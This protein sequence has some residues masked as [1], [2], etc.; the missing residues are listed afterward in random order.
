M[1]ALTSLQAIPYNAPDAMF[2]L[3]AEYEADTCKRELH[4]RVLMLSWQHLRRSILDLALIKV[5]KG[6]IGYCHVSARLRSGWRSP[7]PGHEY[8]PLLGLPAFRKGAREVIF[9]KSS[10]LLSGPHVATLQTVSGTGAV[11][12]AAL[13]LREFISPKAK[14]YVSDPS[15]SNHRVIFEFLGFEVDDYPY[16]DEDSG[17]VAF[18]KMLEKMGAADEGSIL[19]LHPCAHNPTGCDLS[20]EQW[21]QVAEVM[22]RRQ[23]FPVLDCAYQG[24]ASGDLDRDG[25]TIRY[26]LE[27]EKLNGLVCQSFSKSMG[28][29]RRASR[30]A[31]RR[32]AF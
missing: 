11:H 31:S 10:V 27:E 23:L 2:A 24:F 7:P 26:M 22:R 3:K 16:Y 8:L 4:E 30:R 17:S 19:I 18:Q 32:C 12:I 25:W 1:A 21:K 29:V 14:V 6:R 13:F 5:K 9:G 28:P 15:W 20:Q